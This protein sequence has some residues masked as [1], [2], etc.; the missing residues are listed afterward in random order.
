MERFPSIGRVLSVADRGLLSLDNLD[1]LSEIRLDRGEP[2]EF[3]LVVP[4]RR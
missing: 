3:V 4:G 1:A 2:L